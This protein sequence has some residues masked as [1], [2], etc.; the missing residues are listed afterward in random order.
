M[1]TTGVLLYGRF[2]IIFSLRI[3]KSITCV[4][5]LLSLFH[6]VNHRSTDSSNRNSHTFNCRMLVNPHA[7]GEARQAVDQQDASQQKYETMQCFAVSEPKS[8][9]EEGEGMLS[10]PYC[11]VCI[12]ISSFL[13]MSFIWVWF[14]FMYLFSPSLPLVLVTYQPTNLQSL[15]QLSFFNCLLICLLKPSFSVIF[16]SLDLSL[17]KGSGSSFFF[18]FLPS[19]LHVCLD[20]LSLSHHSSQYC[21]PSLLCPVLLPSPLLAL[22]PLPVHWERLIS[23]WHF[24]SFPSNPITHT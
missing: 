4:C 16:L 18:C 3:L 1:F 19:S 15:L 17:F 9:K 21:P 12:Q 20:F 7:D 11:I 6:L 5:L 13:T 2:V 24:V 8:I 22:P 23:V 14:I 10:D